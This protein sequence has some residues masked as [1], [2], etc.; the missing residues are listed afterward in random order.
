MLSVA[1]KP[2]RYH[3]LNRNGALVIP[4]LIVNYKGICAAR[5]WQIAS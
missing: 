4:D 2:V 3:I 5:K 1:Q